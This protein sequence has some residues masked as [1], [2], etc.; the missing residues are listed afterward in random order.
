MWWLLP[1]IPLLIL[2]VLLLTRGA[3]RRAQRW[4]DELRAERDRRP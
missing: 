3:E 1:I 2:G 4:L